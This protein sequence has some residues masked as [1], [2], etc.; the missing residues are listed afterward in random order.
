MEIIGVGCLGRVVI[1]TRPD[2]APR[3][4]EN[5]HSLVRGDRG[6]GFEGCVVFQ[7]WRGESVSNYK[8]KRGFLSAGCHGAR[9]SPVS[10]AFRGSLD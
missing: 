9:F 7:C 5:F 2:V 8:K 10:M 4:C 6:Y 1:E 3:M